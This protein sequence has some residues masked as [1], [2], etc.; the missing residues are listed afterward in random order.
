MGEECGEIREYAR[1]FLPEFG[2]YDID[3]EVILDE[4]S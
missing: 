2:I 3:F 4:I 1:K